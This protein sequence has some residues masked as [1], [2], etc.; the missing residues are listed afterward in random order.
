MN[1][2]NVQI[3]GIDKVMATYGKAPE[4]TLAAVKQSIFQITNEVFRKSRDQ[5]VPVRDNPLRDSGGISFKNEATSVTG[6][7]TYNTPYAVFVHENTDPSINYTKAG[8]GPKYLEIP[9]MEMAEKL[10]ETFK[11]LMTRYL[12]A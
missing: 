6:E 12:K 5:L 8:T 9:T 1:K 3:V 11:R 4:V 7:I 10:P 2:M